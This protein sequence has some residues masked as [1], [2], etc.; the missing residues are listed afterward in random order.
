MSIS[1]V[2]FQP[3]IPQNTGTIIRLA[4]CLDVELHIIHPTGFPFSQKHLKRYG[5]DYIDF[6]VIKEH[7][8]FEAFEKWR[9]EKQKRLVLLSTKASVSIYHNK[10]SHDDILM[11]GRESAG[12]PIDVANCSDIKLRIPMN[13][14]MRSLNIAVSAAMVLG[15]AKRQLGEFD[16]LV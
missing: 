10:F 8:S 2:L 6:S 3:D 16:D 11:M 12:V 4:A 9:K 5:M 15:E 1:L 13:K 7:I 14:E